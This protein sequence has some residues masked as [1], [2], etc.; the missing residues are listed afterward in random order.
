MHDSTFSTY[1]CARASTI[2]PIAAKPSKIASTAT[3]KGNS[4]R[5][6]MRVAKSGSRSSR[7]WR[8]ISRSA[9]RTRS[10]RRATLRA[11]ARPMNAAVNLLAREGRRQS[12]EQEHVWHVEG[13]RGLGA[14]AE[15][16]T[17]RGG[18]VLVDFARDHNPRG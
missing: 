13:L 16:P 17:N 5:G 15:R 8:E 4:R 14:R 3:N 2:S 10:T 9:A 12:V 11:K 6:A 7:R 1:Y 18:A